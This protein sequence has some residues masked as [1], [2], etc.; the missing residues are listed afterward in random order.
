[1][2]PLQYA[3]IIKKEDSVP[4]APYV[5]LSSEYAFF[6]SVPFTGTEYVRLFIGTDVYP[7]KSPVSENGKVSFKATIAHEI[8]GQREAY[9]KGWTQPEGNCLPGTIME[10]IQASIRA[11][12]FTP[13]LLYS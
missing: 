9:L 8:V 3:C 4:Y 5:P 13:D 7:S 12:R 1:M 2:Y 10:E 6:A 11:A